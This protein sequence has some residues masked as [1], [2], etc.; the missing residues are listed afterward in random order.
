MTICARQ[1]RLTSWL[2]T[3]LPKSVLSG[4]PVPRPG[5]QQARV[6][7]MCGG[8]R[9]I[10]T[11]ISLVTIR[12]GRRRCTAPGVSCSLSGSHALFSSFTGRRALCQVTHNE[13][14]IF[15]GPIGDVPNAARRRT[16]L[17]VALQSD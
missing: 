3:G 7:A 11:N 8:I 16:H 2:T 4:N 17:T 13:T 15:F 9:Y 1:I 5:I 14:G 10:T 6:L 12:T